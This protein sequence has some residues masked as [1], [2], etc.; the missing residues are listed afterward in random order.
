MST[1]PE[2]EFDS[3]FYVRCEDVESCPVGWA[4]AEWQPHYHFVGSPTRAAETV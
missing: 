3:E 4:F 1:S 2:P